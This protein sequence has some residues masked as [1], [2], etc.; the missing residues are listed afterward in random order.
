[1]FVE[2]PVTDMQL[3]EEREEEAVFMAEKDAVLLFVGTAVPL[4]L[5][6]MDGVYVTLTHIDV[7]AVLEREDDAHVEAHPEMLREWLEVD[8]TVTHAVMDTVRQ[9]LLDD[10]PR[11]LV[12]ADLEGEMEPVRV[13]E[14]V[15]DLE[16]V[17]EVVLHA[18]PEAHLDAVRETVGVVDSVVERVRL[19]LNDVVMV[20]LVETERLALLL[21]LILAE[22]LLLPLYDTLPEE[23]LDELSDVLEVLHVDALPVVL[24]LCDGE[25]VADGDEDGE[26]EVETQGDPDEDWLD[27]RDEEGLFEADNDEQ[28][29]AVTDGHADVETVLQTLTQPEAVDEWLRVEERDGVTLSDAVVVLERHSDGLPL[30][31]LDCDA[32]TEIVILLL[33]V[34]DTVPVRLTVIVTLRVRVTLAHAERV[35]RAEAVCDA[36]PV[37]DIDAHVETVLL[38]DAQALRL[39]AEEPDRDTDGLPL[40]VVHRDG[41]VDIDGDRLDVREMLEH[42]LGDPQC[43]GDVV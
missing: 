33:F 35:E 14:S 29:V 9:L 24:T 31:Q 27:D 5:S 7:V 8:V 18:E 10:V 23:Q 19:R 20:E 1:M 25:W 26:V 41:D 13:T 30:M 12:V 38:A 28:V 4:F 37:L 15:G 16:G 34:L 39:L 2:V 42:V 40:E 3:D 17:R 43:E 11:R 32:D 22:A 36:H 6:E 21:P